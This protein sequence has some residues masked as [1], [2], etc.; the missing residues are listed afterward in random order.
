VNVSSVFAGRNVRRVR[1]DSYGALKDGTGDTI[2][3][4]LTGGAHDKGLG[5][6]TLANIQ[7]QYPSPAAVTLS[8]TIDEVSWRKAFQTA[9]AYKRARIVFGAG[10]YVFTQQSSVFSYIQNGQRLLE[11][12]GAGK[13]A[14]TLKRK[15]GAVPTTTSPPGLTM[16]SIAVSSAT[17]GTFKM[18]G[19][20]LDGNAAGNPVPDPIPAEWDYS[21][22]NAG[23]Y[24]DQAATFKLVSLNAA[25]KVDYCHFYDMHTTDPMADSIAPVFN[26]TG[27][28]CKELT[29]RRITGD[30]RN[31]T[32][33]DVIWNTGI[34]VVRAEDCNVP[35]LECEHKTVPATERR[36]Y[37]ARCTADVLDI[38][39]DASDPGRLIV[40]LSESTATSAFWWGF[41]GGI[42]KDCDLRMNGDG[43]RINYPHVTEFR[44]CTIR[45][46][47]TGSTVR[48]VQIFRSA[49]QVQTSDVWF[50][51]CDFVIDDAGPGPFAGGQM[52]PTSVTA[53]YFDGVKDRTRLTACTFDAR[54]QYSIFSSRNGHII[55]EGCTIRGTVAGVQ[56]NQGSAPT[57]Y[58]RWID[59]GSDFSGCAKPFSVTGTSYAANTFVELSGTWPASWD[60]IHGDSQAKIDLVTWTSARVVQVTGGSPTQGIAGDDVVRTDPVSGQPR[61]WTLTDTKLTGVGATV[62]E[63]EP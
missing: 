2:A 31:R 17:L 51:R 11:I 61:R 12:V 63:T 49:A 9:K 37:I 24:W 7:T 29:F 21:P 14:T 48:G 18:R 43:S 13:T 34:E 56:I 35:T 19:I 27:F 45:L 25:G 47:L 26:D 20:R 55:T 33:A 3:E 5:W 53:A 50:N 60:P 39:S 42:V 1:V 22:Y 52:N 15:S 41:A 59:N 23:Y 44:D 58:S 62:T 57:L 8:D 28:Q 38:A 4:W 16:I 10:T 36:V 6:T 30:N 40:E 32:R 46:T 54:G